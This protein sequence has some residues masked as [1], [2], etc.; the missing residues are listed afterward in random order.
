MSGSIDRELGQISAHLENINKKLDDH[1][2]KI[3]AIDDRLRTVERKSALNGAVAGGIVTVTIG[4]IK[5]QFTGG[6]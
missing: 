2:T 4:L 6:S 5:G 1:G 3:D